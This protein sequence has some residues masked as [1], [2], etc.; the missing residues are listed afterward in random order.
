MNLANRITLVRILMIPIFVFIA[1]IEI[2]HGKL[3]LALIFIIAAV[4]DG[5]DGHIARKRKEITVLGKFMDPLADKLLM[6][7]ALIV[8]VGMNSVPAWIA[9]VIISREFI[10]TGLRTIAA[11]KGEIIAAS[12]A[13]KQKT[14]TQIIAISALLL[15]DDLISLQ[16]LPASAITI[17]AQAMLWIALIFTVYSG[18]DYLVKGWGLLFETK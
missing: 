8:L 5:L 2:P 16:F 3:V 4:T 12:K 14:V 18:V 9:I 1:A 17:F 10:V 15:Q 11:A 7:A 13:G 6:S